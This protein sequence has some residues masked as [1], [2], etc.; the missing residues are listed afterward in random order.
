LIEH[1]EI[2]RQITKCEGADIIPSQLTGPGEANPAFCRY[3][4]FWGLPPG[5]EAWPVMPQFSFMQMVFPPPYVPAAPQ[6]PDE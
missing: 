4:P 5:T 2:P 1:P 3:P 6:E